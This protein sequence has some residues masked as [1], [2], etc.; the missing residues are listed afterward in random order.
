MFLYNEQVLWLY[1]PSEKQA[2]KQDRKT[3]QLPAALA[4][5]MGK[6]SRFNRSM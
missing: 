2:F 3:S 4:F 6:G 1:E 5:L